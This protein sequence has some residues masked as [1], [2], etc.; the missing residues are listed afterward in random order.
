[1]PENSNTVRTEASTN[2]VPLDTASFMLINAVKW[3]LLLVHNKTNSGVSA[4]KVKF[5]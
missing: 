4:Y 1:M 5:P 3:I 2:D